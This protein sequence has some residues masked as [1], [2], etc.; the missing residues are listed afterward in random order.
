MDELIQNLSYSVRQ[1]ARKPGFAAVLMVTLALGVGG[2]HG[3]LQRCARR[4]SSLARIR[5]DIEFDKVGLRGR[6]LW[7]W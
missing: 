6:P 3:G 2:E 7:V 5:R 4:A 1:M